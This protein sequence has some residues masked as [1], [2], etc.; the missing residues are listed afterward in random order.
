M[1][2]LNSSLLRQFLRNLYKSVIVSR[3]CAQK[4]GYKIFFERYEAKVSSNG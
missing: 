1:F 2:F 3:V 4:D